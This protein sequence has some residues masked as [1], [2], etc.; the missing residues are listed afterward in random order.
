MKI[1]PLLSYL[2]GCAQGGQSVA[3]ITLPQCIRAL[4]NLS[5]R[6]N[7]AAKIGTYAA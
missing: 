2:K 3:T 6:L 4:V 1:V 7:S 5:L